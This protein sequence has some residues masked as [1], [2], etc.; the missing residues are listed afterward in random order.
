MVEVV[1]RKDGVFNDYGVLQDCFKIMESNFQIKSILFSSSYAVK[2]DSNQVSIE[3][4]SRFDSYEFFNVSN[5]RVNIRTVKSREPFFL[6]EVQLP[7]VPIEALRVDLEL[8]LVP[9]QIIP[10]GRFSLFSQKC[11]RVFNSEELESILK[12]FS[13]KVTRASLLFMTYEE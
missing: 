4:D 7:F 3:K 11:F 6:V 2:I 12:E 1:E 10:R 8:F 5:H 9:I 13:S